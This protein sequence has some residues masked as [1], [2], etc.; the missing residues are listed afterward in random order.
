MDSILE[1]LVSKSLSTWQFGGKMIPRKIA[2]MADAGAVAVML[3][4]NIVFF[5]KVSI[6]NYVGF[7]KRYPND[8]EIEWSFTSEI[9]IKPKKE[10][11]M[12]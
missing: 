12:R 10:E 9:H 5:I 3:L 6:T 1:T 11:E 2:Q 7:L 8:S 4:R